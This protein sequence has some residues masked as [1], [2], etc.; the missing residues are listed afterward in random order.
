MK[1][2]MAGSA[3]TLGAFSFW[4]KLSAAA[5]E[6]AFPAPLYAALPGRERHRPGGL[7]PGRHPDHGEAADPHHAL[8]CECAGRDPASRTTHTH[9]THNTHTHTCLYIHIH[10]HTHTHPTKHTHTHIRVS[11]Y[12]YTHTHTHTQQSLFLAACPAG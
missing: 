8:S 12:T 10:T 3:A 5:P 2:D 9:N 11:T 4:A 7:P 6:L 1:S